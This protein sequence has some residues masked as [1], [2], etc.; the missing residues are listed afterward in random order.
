MAGL[1]T[2]I[3]AGGKATRLYP[4]TMGVSKQLLPIYDKPCVYY[5]ISVAMLAGSREILVI[6]NP[7]N[8]ES[9]QRLLGDG[10]NLGVSFSYAGQ[11][12]PGGIAQAFLVAEDCGFLKEGE[13]CCLIL[14]DNIFHSTGLTSK[15]KAAAK[16]AKY[17]RASVFGYYVAGDA[18]KRYGVA[19]VDKSTKVG[20][21]FYL[22]T[23]IEEKPE[24]PRSHYA[25]VGLY[26]YPGTVLEKVKQ[27]KPSARGELEITDLNGAYIMDGGN[28]LG[29]HLLSRGTVWF[30]SGTFDSLLEASNYVQAIQKRTGCEIANLAEIAYNNGWIDGEK[31]LENAKAVEKTEHGEYLAKIYLCECTT[32]DDD[33]E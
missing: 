20:N 13:P 11:E 5:P 18:I 32:A 2:I 10:S 28:R 30:D 12:K 22:C 14:G 15:L 27:L 3:L 7:E 33:D 25:V 9:F 26:F 8:I 6:T 23:G 19:V 21:G 16:M 24:H 29:I 1:K 4:V 31:L 17:G